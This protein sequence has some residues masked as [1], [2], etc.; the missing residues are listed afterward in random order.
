MKQ[1]LSAEEV[2]WNPT[3]CEFLLVYYIKS[4]NYFEIKI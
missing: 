4:I 2:R 1:N 3:I